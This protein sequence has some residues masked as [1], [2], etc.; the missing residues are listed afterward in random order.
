MYGAYGSYTER[1]GISLEHSSTI[2]L[3]EPVEARFYNNKAVRG[4]ALYVSAESSIQILPQRVYSLDNITKME[5]ALYFTNNTNYLNAPNSLFAPSLFFTRLSPSPKFLIGFGDW[6][7]NPLHSH[8]QFAYSTVF[9]TILKEM[10]EFDKF[11]SLPNGICWQLHG[12][13][14]Q[15][16]YTDYLLLSVVPYAANFHTYPRE[17]AITISYSY[18]HV[19]SVRQVS[20]SNSDL[21]IGYLDTSL[22]KNNS[23]IIA[24][25]GN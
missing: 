13:K 23:T 5:I 16:T 25:F 9:D 21:R 8:I 6:D 14:W 7:R 11:T 12:Q 2:F 24:V 4:S 17:K 10:N 18:D 20:C 3:K 22:H 19:F 15:C 1:G